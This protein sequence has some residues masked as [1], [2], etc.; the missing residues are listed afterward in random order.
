[1]NPD[2][3]RNL[4]VYNGGLLTGRRIRRIL[5]LAGWD[6]RL[7]LPGP[8][9]WVGVWGQSPTAPRGE[10]VA[11]HTDTPILRVEDAFLRSVRT[12]RS[13]E[14]P[15]GLCLDKTGLH[16]DPS[17]RSDIETL[18]ASEP[19]DDTAMLDAA[20]AAIERMTYWQVSK[21]NDFDPRADLPQAPYILI[22]DQTRGDASVTASG[23][24]ADTFRD[25]LVQAR[26]DFPG[27]QVYIKSHPETA[28]GHRPGHFDDSDLSDNVAFLSDPLPPFALMQGA[29]A[30]YTVSSQMGFDAIFAGHRP[31]VF[32]Q[33]FYA[34]WGLT[35]DR[36]PM[37]RRG[38]NLTRAQLFAASMMLYPTWYDPH[39][40]AL[41]SVDQV[42]DMLAARARAHREDR[43]GYAAT[44]IRRWK[45]PHMR[46][47]FGQSNGI[48]FHASPETARRKPRHMM[49][50]GAAPDIE[51]PVIRVEDGFVRSR[52][53][54]AELVP[55]LSLVADDIGI[56]YAATRP[57]ALENLIADTGGLPAAER[58]RADRLIARLTRDRITKYN[59]GTA[60]P[61][62]LKPGHRILVPGQVEDDA[63]IE[64]GC[65]GIRTNAA[66][67][68]ET[69]AKNPDAVI[70]YKPHPDVQAGLRKGHVTDAD[71]LAHAE[72]IL[73][74]IDAAT[75]IDLSDEVWTMTSTL[76]FE[77]LLRGK[78]VTCLGMPFYA[79]WGLTR[80]LGIRQLRRQA[81]PDLTA[82][83]HACLIGY[84]RYVDPVTGDPCP[85]EVALDRLSDTTPAQSPRN[86]L[87]AGLQRLLPR[88]T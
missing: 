55:P 5:D 4:Y 71:I 80:D 29:L 84:P 50:W 63:S 20:R 16:F 14:P 32:G 79:G 58:A 53:L 62:D 74:D 7:G 54:G 18:L 42:I 69:R 2:D 39:A 70:V 76:G 6:V 22:I 47:F 88:S 8:D 12:G 87:L 27:A 75:A 49:V 36:D 10:T 46:R 40:D 68:A 33:P 31:R 13:G 26:S 24:T 41:C 82:L 37:P 19:L 21:Y 15:L 23:A 86:K 72:H 25:M 30:V 56:Y 85:V 57:S 44:N 61:P 83:A 34:G 17:G 9:D 59:L 78:P 43:A 60:A 77:A 1:M 51:A 28:S 48:T 11:A 38:R 64:L 3:R 67:L 52:G 65:D 45:R 66:L 81:R 35:D 73:T